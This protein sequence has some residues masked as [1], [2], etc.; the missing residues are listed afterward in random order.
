MPTD[1]DT[2]PPVISRNVKLG[3]G[4]QSI[5]GQIAFDET[6]RASIAAFLDIES[7]EAFTFDYRLTPISSDR[8]RL[9]ADLR[10]RLTQSCVVTLEP[11]AEEVRDEIVLDCWPEG[12]IPADGADVEAAIGLE[13]LPEDP[14]VPIVNRTI[15]LGAL[16]VELLA[17]ALNP[18]PRKADADFDWQDPKTAAE[19]NPFNPFSELSKLKSK[20]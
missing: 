12:Q 2:P 15:D 20:N 8:F 9:E 18:Y 19:D 14:P 6:S 4:R 10:A 7:L 1:G 3:D 17:S 5:A 11:V 13:A 16:A